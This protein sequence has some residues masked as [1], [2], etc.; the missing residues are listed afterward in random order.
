MLNISIRKYYTN[1]KAKVQINIENDQLLTKKL[2][3]EVIISFNLFAG[4][5]LGDIA[6]FWLH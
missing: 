4:K 6:Y 1:K 2:L 3:H 5:V